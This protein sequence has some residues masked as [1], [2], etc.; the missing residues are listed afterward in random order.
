MAKDGAPAAADNAGSRAATPVLPPITP[1]PGDKKGEGDANGEA[2]VEEDEYLN[3]NFRSG[4]TLRADRVIEKLN[5]I[6][7]EAGA[8]PL[9]GV[10]DP[11]T[12]TR[13]A[14][15]RQARKELARRRQLLERYE[16]N[17]E[18][19]ISIRKELGCPEDADEEEE[20]DTMYSEEVVSGLRAT[21]RTLRRDLRTSEKERAAMTK[22]IDD[23]E[24]LVTEAESQRRSAEGRVATMKKL[25][26]QAEKRA[27]AFEDKERS[28]KEELNQNKAEDRE[29]ALGKKLQESEQTVLK[30][31]AQL[32]AAGR[33]EGIL[34]TKV[35]ALRHELSLEK[36]RMTRLLESPERRK[37]Q[38]KIERMR[39]EDEAAAKIQAQ[40][41]GAQ[42]RK[43]AD[44]AMRAATGIQA[45]YRR[46]RAARDLQ[47]KTKQNIIDARKST[48][49]LGKVRQELTDMERKRDLAAMDC[50]GFESKLSSAKQ[51]LVDITKQLQETRQ[52]LTAALTLKGRSAAQGLLSRWKEVEA[53]N[54]ALA[55]A[56]LEEQAL[57]EARIARQAEEQVSNIVER[58]ADQQP[59]RD[60]EEH[61][62]KKGQEEEEEEYGDEDFE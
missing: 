59:T 37:I 33:R 47:A 29:S 39:L 21:V 5:A 31:E 45:E 30:Q 56:K 38:E 19:M 58:Q 25:V 13:E 1:E 41:R 43:T 42:A 46:R 9:P 12:C 14:E 61:E 54:A 51:E 52:A 62:A 16:R 26:L 2:P 15:R 4:Y 57:S 18:Q 27:V 8:L 20:R 7:I 48:A 23:L 17:R 44:L 55:Q 40:A 11:E 24:R 49:R 34:K 36:D 35:K 28:F 3:P 10:T 32:V 60:S 53:I 50:E 6:G 22:R